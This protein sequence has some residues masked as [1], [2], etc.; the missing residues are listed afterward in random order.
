MNTAIEFNNIKK[1]YGD[2]VILEGL[3]FSVAK[4]EFITIIGSSGCGK[5]TALKMINGLIE[6][7]SGDIFVDGESIRNKNLTEL[8]RNIGYAI[9]GSVLFPHMTVEQNISYVPNLINKKNKEKTNL[10]VFKWMQLVGLDEELK[11]RYPSELSGGQQQRV[12]I[13]RALAASPDILLMDEPFG[14]V[15][16]I[17]RG[18]LQNELKQI[19]QK[20]GITILFVTHDISEALKLGT[21]VIVMDKGQIQQYDEPNELLRNPKTDFVKQLVDEERRACFLPDEQLKDCEYSG[22]YHPVMSEG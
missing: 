13:A 8:R 17:T 6:P 4:G 15:D 2:K 12:G 19:H 7:T 16:E 3:T 10:A 18:Q 5:T 9:Q 21:K 14:A 11:D 1:V 20:T 22:V